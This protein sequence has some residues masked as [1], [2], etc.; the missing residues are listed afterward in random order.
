[1][2]GYILTAYSRLLNDETSVSSGFSTEG[3]VT[4][5]CRHIPPIPLGRQLCIPRRAKTLTSAREL[6]HRK[7]AGE[8]GGRRR[9]SWGGGLFQVEARSK[10]K[11]IRQ[12]KDQRTSQRVRG[13]GKMRVSIGSRTEVCVAV[14]SQ[15][16]WPVSLTRH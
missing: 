1:M 10:D 16:T 12:D 11:I 14:S 15:H 8:G 2:H 9:G 6:C 5:A 3:I 13:T 4:S 7:E